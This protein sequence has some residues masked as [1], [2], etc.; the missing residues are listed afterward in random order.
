[1]RSE[2]SGI[3]NLP[4]NVCGHQTNPSTYTYLPAA[5]KQHN[6]RSHLPDCACRGGEREG[7]YAIYCRR[8]RRHRDPTYMP[9]LPATGDW[10]CI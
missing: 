7:L 9:T 1:M 3:W 8:R 6:A 4:D 10:T 5:S 2:K